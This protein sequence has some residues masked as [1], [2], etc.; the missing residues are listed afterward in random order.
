[1]TITNTEALHTLANA[2]GVATEYWDFHGEHRQVTHSTL[3]AV[4]AALGVEI[5][6]DD[7]VARA[8]TEHANEPWRHLLP[9]CTVVRSGQEHNLAVHVPDGVGV[10]VYVD[11]EDGGRWELSQ[12]DVW[13]Q[14]QQIDGQ[15]RGRATFLIPADLPLGW[16]TLTAERADGV[17][18]QAPLAITPQR[19]PEPQL[20]TSRGWGAMAQLY[21]VRSAQSW[22]M[23]DARDLAEMGSFFGAVGA[24]FLLINPLHATHLQTPIT[25]SP[26]LPTSR[27]FVSPLYIRPEDIPEVAYL[28]G[29]QRSLVQWAAED[30]RALSHTGDPIDRD[31][32]WKAKNQALAVIY[33]HGLTD[34][35]RRAFERFKE[36]MGPGL[37]DFS[38]WCALA[39]KYGEQPWPTGYHH[40]HATRAEL[41][42]F[43]LRE[44]IEYFSWLQWIIDQQLERAQH[45]ARASGMGLGLMHDLAVGVHP[46]GAD[47]WA[48]QDVFAHG[49]GVGAPPDMYNQ[50][51]QNWSQPPWRPDALARAGY[52]PLRDMLATVLRHA[53]AIRVDHVMGFFRLWWIP[54]G[55]SPQE[56]TYVRFDHEAMIGVLLLEAYRAGAVLI[57]EDLGTVEPWVRDYLQ[58]RGIYG[59]SV[60][61]FE[62]DDDGGPRRPENYRAEVL[63]T[64]DTHDMPPA[65]GYLA[66][67]HVDLRESLGL[68][69]DPVEEVRAQAE[70]ERERMIARLHEYELL[71]DR[72]TEREIVEA[73]HRYIVLTSSRLL[74]VAVTDMVG[75]R[76]TQNQPGTDT[77][78]PNWKLP[79]AD[80]SG[81]VVLVE[82]LPKN[83]RLISLLTAM[84]D[85]LGNDDRLR[86]TGSE[87]DRYA[88]EL[89]GRKDSQYRPRHGE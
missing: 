58:E 29:P 54:D 70:A 67:E 11:L 36:Q 51:G 15:M 35:R 87:Y 77:E 48:L 40:P 80:G 84:R 83:G 49:I 17:S 23:G 5:K 27:R 18:A 8:L 26:Y 56:G 46:H 42:R 88:A 21:S 9:P 2:Y 85:Q 60:L 1:M 57:G 55:A 53:G 12:K 69:V 19:L 62:S 7:D 32:V 72:P 6:N 39:E 75:E 50:Q 37:E 33:A 59:T 61:W 24:D 74:G 45:D 71:G 38:L 86:E 13:V 41:A 22:G 78:Y 47:V 82:D 14:P 30:V 44:R 52:R 34:A 76:R 79:L 3:Q 25:P 31:A 16:H 64:V 28:T 63:A 43:E 73:M 10:K 65:A 89:R 20:D 81:Q 4:L 66:G 68:L